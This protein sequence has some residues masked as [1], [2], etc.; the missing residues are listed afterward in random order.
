MTATAVL[1][2]PIAYAL[3]GGCYSTYSL[4]AAD[5]NGDGKPDII[6]ADG[7][8]GAVTV[9][10]NDGHGGLGSPTSYTDGTGAYTGYAMTVADLNGDG[11]PD[12]VAA[13]SGNS[14]SVLLGDGHGGFGA[15]AQYSLA[16]AQTGRRWLT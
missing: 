3:N 4:A 1:A 7:N 14:V 6:A 2:R 11:K 9:L 10:L 8:D 13:Q 12:V 5:L 15:P 16:S